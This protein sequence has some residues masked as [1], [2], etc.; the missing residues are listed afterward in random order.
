MD[1]EHNLKQQ[2][3]STIYNGREYSLEYNVV[4]RSLWEFHCS[5]IPNIVTNIKLHEI[6]DRLIEYALRYMARN[7]IRILENGSCYHVKD[8]LDKAKDLQFLLKYEE[9]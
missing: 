7:N 5:Y 2:R 4:E 1:I 9:D 8:Y 3:F 6:Q